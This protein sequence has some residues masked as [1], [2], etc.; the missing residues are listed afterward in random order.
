[1]ELDVRKIVQVA[2]T[3]P[4]DF[5]CQPFSFRWNAPVLEVWH[6]HGRAQSIVNSSRVS[7]QLGFNL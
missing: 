7:D 6:E 3:A 5:N 1:M 4:T 2:M